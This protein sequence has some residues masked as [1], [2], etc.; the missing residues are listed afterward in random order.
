MIIRLP[1]ITPINTL[2]LPCDFEERVQE[3]FAKFTEMTA[4]EYTDEDRLAYIG[5]LQTA[6]IRRYEPE[7]EVKNMILSQT[8]YEIE[9]NGDFPDKEDFWNFDF[10]CQCYEKGLED[11]GYKKRNYEVDHHDNSK[12]MKAI[13][14]I[15]RIVMSWEVSE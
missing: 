2:D 10:M 6:Y 12:T 7:E 14:E 11:G 8:E 13:A 5:N 3:S 15:I 9:E 4:K 1:H